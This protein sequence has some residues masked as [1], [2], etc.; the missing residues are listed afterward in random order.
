[1]LPLQFGRVGEEMVFEGWAGD[2]DRAICAIE[3]SI[4]GGTSWTSHET[5]G[6]TSDRLVKWKF[7]YTP[8]AP[9][10]Y[11]LLVRS[12]NDRGE[13]STEP[14]GVSFSVA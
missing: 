10:E 3:F 11:R 14:D 2:Y 1:M 5:P 9:G 12:V 7:A 6:A 13:A 4:D 8:E